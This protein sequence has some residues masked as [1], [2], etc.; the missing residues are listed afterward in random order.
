MDCAEE[1]S[2]LRRELSKVTGVFDLRFD[3]LQSKMIV[4]F[5]PAKVSDDSIRR[6]VK[7]LGME[8]ELWREEAAGRPPSGFWKRHG[9][10]LSTLIS[11]TAL[12]AAVLEDAITSGNLLLAFLT[13][14]EAGGAPGG[15]R[16]ALFF[17]ALTAGFAPSLPKALQS[18]RAFRAD[19]N[20]LMLVSI[21]GALVLGEYSE[22]ATVSFL[23]ALANY[24]E[25]WSLSKAK[26]AIQGVLDIAPTEATVRHGDH[27]HR[28]P[29][30]KVKPGD[31]VLVRPGDKIPCD[32]EVV[33]GRSTV[34]QAIL[35]GESVPVLKSVGSLVYAGTINGNGAL[36]IRSTRQAS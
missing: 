25:S 34:D 16:T 6:T 12:L 9:R 18:L 14:G 3:V 31:L 30:A 8:A 13:Q 22:A 26:R 27:E 24:M 21:T 15:V 5:N 1:V 11:G 4:E 36:E 29:A 20:V 19:M 33:E 10:S 28:V 2:L 32:G 35:T 7:G 23:F 17:T